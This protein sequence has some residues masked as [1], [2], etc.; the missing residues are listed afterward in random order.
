MNRQGKAA[1]LLCTALSVSSLWGCGQSTEEEKTVED[2]AVVEAAN[3]EIGSLKLSGTFIATISPDESVYVIPKTTGEVVDV[4]VEV[5]DTVQE[6]DVLAVLDDTMAQ[7]SVKSAQIS[8][9]NARHSYNLSYGDGASTLNDMQSDNTISQ[10]EDGVNKLQENLVDA[11]DSLEK[12]KKQ[13]KEAEDELADLKEEYD[14][15]EDVDEI[16]DYAE[17]FDKNDMEEAAD[18]AAAM[19]RYQAA[20]AEVAP[21]EAK[22]TQYKSAVDQCEE[23]IETIQDNIDSTYDSYSQAVTSSNISN[24]EMREEQKKVS[25]NSISAAKLNIEQA[26]ESLEAYTITAAISGVVES[27]NVD[28]HD[29]ASSGSPA[30]VISNKDT[31]VAT[32]Y[33]SEDVRNTFSTGQKITLEKDR[34]TY[35]GEIVEIGSAVDTA[36]GLF[37][38]KAAVKGDTSDLLSGT[39]AT[40]TTDTYYVDNAVIIPYDSV[41]YDGTQAYVYTVAD[42]LARKVNVTTGL[43]DT[44]NIVITEGLASDDMVITTWSA[45]LR[46]GVAVSV[47][48]AEQAQE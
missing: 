1:L 24:G 7:L 17:S 27:V 4:L 48:D 29:F 20:A 19:T 13:L 8:L 3:P 14:F 12:T 38:V 37:M 10:A 18:Y 21:V 40:V 46:D 33:V 23:A 22:I 15:N 26:Q 32:Y 9:D 45:Q 31:M 11:M 5:G 42:G 16:K 39:K 44:D 2:V 41:Y 43:Y 47:K 30:F 34:K 25:Q 6:G 36:T 28:V 35:D